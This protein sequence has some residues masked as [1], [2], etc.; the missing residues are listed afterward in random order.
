M[1]KLC[2]INKFQTTYAT[3]NNKNNKRFS[4]G[5]FYVIQKSDDRKEMLNKSLLE[6]SFTFELVIARVTEKFESYSSNWEIWIKTVIGRVNC[7]AHF[8]YF[9]LVIGQI[10]HW[11]TVSHRK[12]N[13]NLYEGKT[14]KVVN[15]WPQVS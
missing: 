13:Y 6:S 10:F 8:A 7:Y 4:Y 14:A 9:V 12:S 11:H 5:R 15:R 1:R 3:K 2:W